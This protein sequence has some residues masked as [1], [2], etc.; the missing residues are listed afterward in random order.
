MAIIK[1]KPTTPGRRNM[2]QN[3]FAEITKSYPEKSLIV[4]K[5]SQAGRNNY[6]R[7]TVRHRGGGHRRAYRLVDFKQLDKMGIPAT[8]RAIEYDPNRSAYIALV[9]YADGEKRYILAAEGLK[10]GD[11]IVAKEKAK[12]K[13]GNRMHLNNI[14]VGFEIYN[15][16]INKGKGGQL[17]R[18]AGSTAKLTS[19]EGQY[20][21]VQLPS[22]EIRFVHKNCFASIGRLS[23][24]QHNQVRIGKAGRSRWLG[25]R[26]SVLGK[27]MNACDHPHGGG[28]GHSPIGL[29]RPKT[30]W[31]MPALGFKT[32]KRKY[33]NKMIVKRRKK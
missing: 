14:P 11:K 20:A 9:F 29:V 30:P 28:E 12:V 22:G 2:S 3:D 19:L 1:L 21:Q 15:I 31:G 33:S 16:E 17:V 26:P 23:N 13:I 25:R 8:V 18:G 27:S 6:G 10:V 32:R 4:A 7:I 24:L 5:K